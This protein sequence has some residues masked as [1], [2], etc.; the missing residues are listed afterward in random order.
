MFSKN[1]FNALPQQRNFKKKTFFLHTI[2]LE[3]VGLLNLQQGYNLGIVLHVKQIKFF[4]YCSL[5]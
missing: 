3:S 4:F 1:S 5:S 2:I